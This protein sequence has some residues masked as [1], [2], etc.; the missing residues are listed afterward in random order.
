MRLAL[1]SDKKRIGGRQRWILPMAVGRVEDVSDVTDA[2]LD[3]ALRTISG[4][5]P[6][7]TPRRTPRPKVAAAVA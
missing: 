3:L 2:E 5:T 7:R 4:E 6:A 1:G